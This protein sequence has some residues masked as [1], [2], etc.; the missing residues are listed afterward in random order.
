MCRIAAYAGPSLPL[1]DFLLK[2]A[3]SLYRQSWA[4][5]ELRSAT[6]NADG[7]GFAWLA[8]DD[9]PALYRNP[10]PIWAD[11]NLPGLAR[12]LH[13]RVWVGNVRS[14]T[15][16]LGV[17]ELNTQPF[18]AETILY[19]HNGFIA[20]FAHSLRRHIRGSLDADIEAD[21]H[22]NTDSEYLFALLRQRR[23]DSGDGWD[24]VLG[25]VLRE[26]GERLQSQATPAL[27]NIILADGRCLYASR[28]ALAT[29]CPSLY[30]CTA[31]P[32]FGGGAV[33]ASEAFDDT[34]DWQAVPPH[35]LLAL[36][37]DSSTAHAASLSAL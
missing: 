13:S 16:G 24:S 19:T 29:E 3:H 2:P 8:A 25:G 14:A 30:Y 36:R 6:V 11:I 22:G 20:D 35:Q 23:R 28:H 1:A 18:I 5:R 9:E 26:V 31:H 10:A 32:A 34:A 4:A 7:F 12:S 21:V 27:L 33:I 17:N 37:P 15:E